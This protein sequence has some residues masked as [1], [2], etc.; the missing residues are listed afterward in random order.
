MSNKS[1][2]E[3][4]YE[5]QDLRSKTVLIFFAGLVVMLLVAY[6][7]VT[8]LYKG[9]SH[10]DR[11][12]QAQP[13]PL[14]VDTSSS[15]ERQ[16]VEKRP[17]EAQIKHS[18]PTPRLEEDERGELQDLR[19]PQDAQLATYGWVNEK[20]GVVRIP[21]ER[22]MELIAQRGLPTRPQ[23]G[24]APASPVNV[25]RA[26]ADKSDQASAPKKSRRK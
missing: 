1:H 15:E 7:L 21:I 16:A 12:R 26:A 13:N 19:G 20:S 2:H 23:T 8:S 17:T 6:A 11:T 14:A 3:P 10:Y 25:A 5:Q 24:T 4:D 22:A 9:F 18:F